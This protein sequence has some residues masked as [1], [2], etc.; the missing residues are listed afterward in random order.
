MVA[1]KTA[2]A[3]LDSLCQSRKFG[4]SIFPSMST[5]EI[6]QGSYFLQ[7]DT[8]EGRQALV[9]FP[10]GSQSIKDIKHMKGLESEDEVGDELQALKRAILAG[11][12]GCKFLL[13]SYSWLTA[14]GWLKPNSMKSFKDDC[15]IV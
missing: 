12:G 7:M 6:A 11:N 9:I 3:L 10:P 14:E 8:Q 2:K 15:T 1:I 4:N 13:R 5:L